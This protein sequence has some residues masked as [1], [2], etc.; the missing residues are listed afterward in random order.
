MS[1][2]VLLLNADYTPLKVL[3]WQKAITLLLD[4]KVR[5]VE[6]Y[7][8]RAIRS[9][10][11]TMDFPAVVALRKYVKVSG[12]VKLSRSNILARDG[13]ECMY[14]GVKPKT[15]SGRPC[16]EELTVDHVVPRAQSRNGYVRLERSGQSVPVTC[17]ENVVCACQRC[18]LHKADRTPTQA[19]MKLK[20]VPKRP[21]AWDVIR[22]SLTRTRIPDEWKN[23][24]PEGSPWKGYWDD[25]LVD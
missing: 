14:C 17:W 6:S 10:R 22:M 8:G 1:T 2:Q 13:Y 21:N 5:L 20:T 18:N 19:K 15:E 9:A 11:M 23:Y 3:P 24:L 7:A 25:E 16:I 12:K 4:E